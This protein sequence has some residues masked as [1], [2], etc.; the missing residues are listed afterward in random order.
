[1]PE[2]T[3]P[4][5]VID[6]TV[7]MPV[8]DEAGN[9]AP[10]VGEI[11]AALAGQTSYEI[12]I[13]DDGSEDG[14][15]HEANDLA[16]THDHI[17]ALHHVHGCGQSQAIISGVLIARGEWI[18][19]I[20]GDGQNVPADFQ[21]FLEARASAGREAARTLF[22]GERIKR[23][24]SSLRH[25]ASRF[26]NLVRAAL[27]GDRTPDAGCGLKLLQRD[28]FLRLPHFNSLHR[29][30]PALTMRAG[31]RVVSIPVAH[32]PRTKGRSKYGIWMRG[33]IGVV[34]LLGVIWLK[35]RHTKPTVH[36]RDHK[37]DRSE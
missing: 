16:A 35:L 28:M 32:R 7:V 8:K 11:D 15:S 13:V 33:L 21:K 37:P 23:R 3:T 19:T 31:G 17:R 22:I 24:D 4:K 20:D 6:L 34:D 12:V 25:L 5:P 10:L 2:D 9:V 36:E 29:F 14:T 30:M 26:A 18:A 27:L 1:M